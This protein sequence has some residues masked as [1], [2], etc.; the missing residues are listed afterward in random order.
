MPR[1]I[2]S[3]GVR[4][5]LAGRCLQLLRCRTRAVATADADS[6]HDL[7][8]AAR[9]LEEALRLLEGA[10]P[11]RA[12]RRLKRRARKVRRGLGPIRNADVMASLMSR[13]ARRPGAADR[14]T[15]RAM[16]ARFATDAAELR[17]RARTSGG[18]RVPGV[19]GRVQ[20]VLRASSAG[21]APTLRRTR[22]AVALRRRAFLEALPAARTGGEEEL[23][24]LRI[25]VKKYR[26]TLE[27]LH[28]LGDGRLRAA[29]AS[30]RALQTELGELHDL[31]LLMVRVRRDREGSAASRD[32]VLAQ[33]RAERSRRLRGVLRAID[34]FRPD[35]APS[36]G[37]RRR[38]AAA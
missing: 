37:A 10:L 21:P 26:Y 12:S 2:V 36:T 29:I 30:A 1:E 20:A 4:S 31:D 6:V 11:R 15:M 27:I 16:A 3:E 7:R 23:H 24:A 22:E 32:R 17:R 13:L 38:E 33:L 25:V 8:V 5:L 34:R 19:R 9:R 14:D 18:L 35:H 28:Q